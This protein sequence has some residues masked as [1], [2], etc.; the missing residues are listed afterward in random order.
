MVNLAPS[1]T[2]ATSM[3][4]SQSSPDAKKTEAELGRDEFLMLFIEQLKNQDPMNPME[5]ADFT[6]QLAQFS[7]LEQ[8]FN[9]NTNLA[10]LQDYSATMNRLSALDMIGKLVTFAGSGTVSLVEGVAAVPLK[11]DLA[12][13]AN[14]VTITITDTS[15]QLVDRL[16]VGY[17]DA[18]ARQFTW[19]GTDVNGLPL[20]AGDYRFTVAAIDELGNDVAA[21]IY[22]SGLV[23][24]IET[25][26]DTGETVVLLSS[27]QIAINDIVGVREQNALFE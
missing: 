4:A 25:D 13:N 19:D 10:A 1:A 2:A 6:A 12:D 27:G 5:S 17:Q 16:D 18:G 23:Q 3:F 26:Y 21:T 8:L 7:S 14:Q 20:A 11:F 15:G 22:G 9:V 24:G